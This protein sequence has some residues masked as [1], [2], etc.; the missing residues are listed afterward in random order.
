ML[1]EACLE[2]EDAKGAERAAS[3][4]VSQDNSDYV[5]LISVAKVYLK[6]G[7]IEESIR[8][9]TGIVEQ[10][11]AGREE[12]ELLEIVNEVLTRNPEH[13]GALR[14]LVKIHWWQRDMDAL[15]ASLERMAEAAQAGELADDER[16]ALTQLVRLVPEEQKFMDRLNQIGG[17]QEDAAADNFLPTDRFADVPQFEMFPTAGND[18]PSTS[19]DHTEQF[20]W[21]VVAAE[22]P[23]DASAS[24]AELNETL[25][26]SSI[27]FEEF[28]THRVEP[29]SVQPTG[30]R[31]A[32]SG[33]QSK[34]D[35]MMLQELESVDFY[36]SQG[37]ID[38]AA[39]TLEMLE[40][41][42]GQHPEIQSRRERLKNGGKPAAA[43]PEVFEFGGADELLA[44]KE[45]IATEVE[46]P[47]EVVL[48]PAGRTVAPKDASRM[49]ASP[50][51]AGIDAGLAEIFEEFRIAAEEEQP[52]EREDFETHYNMGTAYKEM[53]LLDDAIHEFQTA[54]S[55]VRAGDGTSRYLQCCTMLGHCFVQK[56][57]PRAAVLWFQKGLDARG[58]EEEQKALRYE[59]ASVFELMGDFEQAHDLFSEVYGV[60]VGYREVGEKLRQVEAKRNRRSKK[61]R[62]TDE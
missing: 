28:E 31:P 62:K 35:A 9:L 38:I 50:P 19:A 6:L 18:A 10:M 3:I 4:L 59:L 54:A 33:E 8:V 48:D 16:Y 47:F 40:R 17:M 51:G 45:V 44:G 21:E 58:H 20:D 60:D 12:N 41:Q 14:L 5:H 23:K 53:D 46:R 24:F 2:A 42:F 32:E 7:E 36:L 1:V 26:P 55:L 37:Y 29:G 25:D 30:G 57:M 13:V 11:L 22:A 61:R 39:D 49:P 27:T 52:A 15:R 34:R 43:K 56:G